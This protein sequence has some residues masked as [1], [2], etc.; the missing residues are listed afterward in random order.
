MTNRGARG[1]L[2]SRLGPLVVAVVVTALLVFAACFVVWHYLG[3]GA[4]RSDVRVDEAYLLTPERLE[5]V[6]AS[7]N[8]APRVTL[9][10]TDVD[11]RIKVKSFS[12]PFRGADDCQDGVWVDLREPLGD[13]VVVDEHTG[14]VVS[15]RTT[16]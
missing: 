13:R 7:C 10:I 8:G 5:L 11:V 3:G 12:T 14:K 4:W 6:V 2:P 16:R 9:W 1:F 15:V